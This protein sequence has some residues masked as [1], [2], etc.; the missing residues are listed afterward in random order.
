[1]CEGDLLQ[2][3]KCH[4]P[5]VRQPVLPVVPASV[6]QVNPTHKG[7]RLVDDDNLLV[8]RP[9]VDGGRDVVWVTHHLENKSP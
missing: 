8:M 4:T 9:Q 2:V 1:M 7:H 6:R 5:N 3:R